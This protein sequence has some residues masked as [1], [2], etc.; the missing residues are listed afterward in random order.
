M[1]LLQMMISI[2][3]FTAYVY[4]S[5]RSLFLNFLFSRTT[6]S[7]GRMM[8]MM[9]VV[10]RVC[11]S[12]LKRKW[13]HY[14]S[15]SCRCSTMQRCLFPKSPHPSIPPSLPIFFYIYSLR[16]ISERLLLLLMG[17]VN[18]RCAHKT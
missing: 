13:Q 16:R 3:F 11:V 10:L 7:I 4:V 5:L 6:F 2:I 15:F 1:L 12:H 17:D 18:H 9:V 8:I 14:S